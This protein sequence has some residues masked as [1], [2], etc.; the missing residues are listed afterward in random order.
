MKIVGKIFVVLTL[1]MSLVLLAFAIS[2]SSWGPHWRAIAK[3]P[4]SE[5]GLGKPLGL[6]YQL[7]NVSAAANQQQDR[8]EQLRN[9]IQRIQRTRL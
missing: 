5:V 3:R 2:I 7:A 4:R 6:E 9:E 1:L 8:N